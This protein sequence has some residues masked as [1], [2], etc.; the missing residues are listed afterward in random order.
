[1]PFHSTYAPKIPSYLYLQHN[2]PILP[3]ISAVNVM[4]ST[5]MIM[6]AIWE[7]INNKKMIATHLFFILDMAHD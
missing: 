1:M 3:N 2:A 6:Q 5:K 4:D 7:L